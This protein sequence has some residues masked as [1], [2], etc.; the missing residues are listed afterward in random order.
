MATALFRSMWQAN[1][2]CPRNG[3]IRSFA[4]VVSTSQM[5]VEPRT[6]IVRSPGGPQYRDEGAHCSS[7]CDHVSQS[8]GGAPVVAKNHKTV[9]HQ[10]RDARPHC[11]QLLGAYIFTTTPQWWRGGRCMF[12]T[13]SA[14]LAAMI[15]VD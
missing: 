5:T 9:D 1:N 2:T 13:S 15:P 14:R 4:P 7:T 12:L 3:S 8:D 6:V 10:K 11:G